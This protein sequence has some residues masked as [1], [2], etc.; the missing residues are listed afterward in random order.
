MDGPGK[1]F[2]ILGMTGAAIDLLKSTHRMDGRGGIDVTIDT[3]ESLFMMNVFRPSVGIYPEGTETTVRE[4]LPQ[5]R[6][7][8]TSQTVTILPGIIT[9]EGGTTEHAEEDAASCDVRKMSNTQ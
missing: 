9:P 7:A 1:G 2:T 8:M 5:G 4:C 6:I 3:G